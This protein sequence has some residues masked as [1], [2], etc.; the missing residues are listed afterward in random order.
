MTEAILEVS[1]LTVRFQGLVALADINLTVGAGEFV[2]VIGPNGAGKTTL[3]N[4]ISGIIPPSEGTVRFC[5]SDMRGRPLHSYARSGMARTFQTPRVFVEY[6]A[7]E[8]ISFALEFS[9]S[10]TDRRQSA[11]ERNARALALLA[12]VGMTDDAGVLS[13]SLPPARQRLLE[14]AM[15]LAARPRLLLLDEVAAGLTEAEV[16][17]VAQ[18]ILGLRQEL[19]FAVIW[20]EHA[21]GVLMQTVDRVVVLQFGRMIADGTPAEVGADP[22]VIEA[23]LGV[24]EDAVV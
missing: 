7:L 15:V 9:G 4:A 21:V 3:F 6:T 23:Y 19:G 16:R 22:Q 13:A 10:A 14:V 8:N 2:G 5:G 17:Q 1:N 20:V 11:A 12:R 24:S 18:L